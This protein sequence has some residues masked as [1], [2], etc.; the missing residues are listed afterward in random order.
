[1]T[2]AAHE[3]LHLRPPT[4]S[5]I[6]D[7]SWAA[8]SPTVRPRPIIFPVCVAGPTDGVAHDDPY[9]RQFWVAAIGAAA[10]ADLLRLAAA[11]RRGHGLRRPIHV[12]TLVR[13]GVVR[14]DQDQLSVPDPLPRLGPKQVARIKRGRHRQLLV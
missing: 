7:V 2:T 14:W 13:E 3:T 4:P 6:A 1:M 12:S 10:V 9:V 8:L 11:A 5:H